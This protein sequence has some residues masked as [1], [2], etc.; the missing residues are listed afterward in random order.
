MSAFREKYINLVF[1]H[2]VVLSALFLIG[3]VIKDASEVRERQEQCAKHCY[4]AKPV[5]SLSLRHCMCIEEEV[6]NVKQEE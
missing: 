1:I 3:Y 4:P 5:K 2:L 6:D